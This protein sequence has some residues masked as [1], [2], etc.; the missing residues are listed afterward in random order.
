VRA[1]QREYDERSAQ[2]LEEMADAIE[3]K[4]TEVQLTAQDSARLLERVLE[5][6]CGP[7]A[8]RLPAVRVESFVTLLREIERLTTSLAKGIATEFGDKP[9]LDHSFDQTPRK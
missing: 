5:E 9:G 3:G 4:P 8:R 6:C 1:Y 2:M 7:D